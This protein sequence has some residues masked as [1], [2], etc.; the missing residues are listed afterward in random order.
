[1]TSIKFYL[2]FPSTEFPIE[3]E[4][5]NDEE[6]LNAYIETLRENMQEAIELRN[7][8]FPQGMDSLSFSPARRGPV[9]PR[10]G[11]AREVDN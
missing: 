10:R 3:V 5:N 8:L 11:P 2:D 1:M 9:E 6:A 7:K 4:V